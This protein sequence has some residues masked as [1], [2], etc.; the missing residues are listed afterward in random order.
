MNLKYW[1]DRLNER[2]FPYRVILARFE[3]SNGNMRDILVKINKDAKSFN[4]LG[5]VYVI[6]KKLLRWNQS[7]KIYQ[8]SYHEN[9]NFPFDT[10]YPEDEINNVLSSQKITNLKTA[11]NPLLVA[12]FI[13]DKITEGLMKSS[14]ILEALRKTSFY[15]LMILIIV[16]LH[17]ALFLHVSGLLSNLNIGI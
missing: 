16:G 14:V 9:Y 17:F 15:I 8:L 11:F 7:S 12:K 3:M 2:F 13:R 10:S 5:G 6:D 1:A 4:L